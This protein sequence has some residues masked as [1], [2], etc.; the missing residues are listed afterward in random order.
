MLYGPESYAYPQPEAPR[1]PLRG[2]IALAGALVLAVLT[3]LTL[4]RQ[5]LPYGLELGIGLGF[6]GVVVLAVVR[7]EAAVFLGLALL[8]V[9]VVD[10]APADFAL[11]VVIAVS[12]ATWRFRA[13]APP[14]ALVALGGFLA[15][16]LLS[17]VEV[18]DHR[19]AALYLGISIY[20]TFAALW[21][22][23]FVDSRRHARIVAAGYLTA[24][25]TAATLGVAAM[26]APVPGKELFAASG[27]ATGLFQDPNVFG[28]FLVP[29][30]LILLEDLLNPRLFR[31]R[32]LLKAAFV[33]LLALAVVLSYSRGA[34]LNL[35]FG[36]VVVLATLGLRRGG[37]R[38]VFRIAVLGGLVAALVVVVLVATGSTG[39][40]FER[41]R[42]QEYDSGRFA[43]Q[44]VGIESAEQYPLG[45]GPGQF[46]SYASISA[47][48]TYVRA[49]AEQGLPGL[50]LVSAFLLSTVAAAVGN[51]IAGRDTYGIGSAA[52]LGGLCGILVNSAVI[53]TLHWRH[54]W[55]VIALIWA[56]WA[57]RPLRRPL[58]P[59]RFV[60]ER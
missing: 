36:I 20:L 33:G 21:L 31:M 2:L 8:G 3:A 60:A 23:G 28:P 19:A 25:A 50:I 39:F 10:P 44:V 51:A 13:N 7:I 41:A 24:A 30:A 18:V 59:A 32:S 53:D 6:V 47:H 17:A 14:V 45:I 22:S 5:P 11:L 35:A 15:L 12:F 26:V 58:A 29:I 37:A 46:E 55:I 43:G 40:L 48:S 57:R 4:S 1:R 27:R 52:L 34:W 42:Y 16:S 9:V 49:L 56:G 38:H 54:L